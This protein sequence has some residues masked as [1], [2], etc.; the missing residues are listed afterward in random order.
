LEVGTVEN[1]SSGTQ[2]QL[3]ET[4]GRPLWAGRGRG[5]A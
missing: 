5:G 2:V 1:L 4:S 3:R